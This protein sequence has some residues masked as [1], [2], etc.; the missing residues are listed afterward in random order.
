MYL[1]LW[2]KGGPAEKAGKK[3]GG[4]SWMPAQCQT[5]GQKGQSLSDDDFQDLEPLTVLG[6]HPCQ[7]LHLSLPAGLYFQSAYIPAVSCD[8]MEHWEV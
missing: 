2:S 1:W 6:I 8:P 4:K 3:G 5:E 7:P